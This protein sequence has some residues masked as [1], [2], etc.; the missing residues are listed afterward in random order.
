MDLATELIFLVVG[1][2]FL[3]KSS[4]WL[5]TGSSLIAERIGV[6][7]LVIGL[8]VVAWGTSAPEVVISSLAAVKDN[9]GQSMG[10]V[11]GSNIANIG[12]VLGIAAMILPDVLNGA[13]ARRE[14]FWLLASV[15]VFWWICSDYSVSRLDGLIL[16][17]LVTV[18]NVQLLWEARQASVGAKP[19]EYDPGN[20]REKYPS[21]LVVI[22]MV[23]LGSA[24]WLTLEGAGGLAKRAGLS[25]EVIGLTVLAVGTSLPELFAGVSG[26][27]KGHS[28]ISIGNVVGSNVFNVT[29]VVGIMALIH[30]FGGPEDPLVQESLRKVVALDFPVVIGFSLAALIFAAMSKMGGGRVKGGLLLLAYIGYMAFRVLTDTGPLG[31]S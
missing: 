24:A 31:S 2:Y 7:Q 22:G 11:L 17:A 9:P 25:D 23:A 6:R 21:I 14:A 26:A 28:E 1:F 18:Y 15:C 4:D 3:A 29:G 30:P 13:L 27:I 8:T 19:A 12:L 5:V 20:W 10:N 16:L